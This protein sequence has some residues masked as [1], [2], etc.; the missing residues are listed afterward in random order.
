MFLATVK[1]DASA[2]IIVG[3]RLRR[4]ACGS[5]RGAARMVRDALATIKCLTRLKRFERLERLER[6]S[7][8]VSTRILLRVD[9][10]FYGSAT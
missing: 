9:S 4:G 10:A 1:T 3:Q 8:M 7:G 2:P 6:L 5:P